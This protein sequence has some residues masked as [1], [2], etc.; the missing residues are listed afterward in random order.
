MVIHVS[1]PS[2]AHTQSQK[3]LEII[4]KGSDPVG[5][6]A[7]QE[8]F[9][10][11]QVAG[12]VIHGHGIPSL[13]RIVVAAGVETLAFEEQHTAF[14][15]HGGYAPDVPFVFTVRFRIG[16]LVAVGNVSRRTNLLGKVAQRKH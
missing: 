4:A 2:T 14:R 7:E 3:L 16:Q 6:R 13:A 12:A 8:V 11:P 15:H 5:G 1:Q 9:L 10:G